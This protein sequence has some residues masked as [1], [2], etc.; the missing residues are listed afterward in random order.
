MTHRILYLPIHVPGT[1]HDKSVKNKRGLREAFERIGDV[2]EMDYVAYPVDALYGR[3]C[4]IVEAFRP[5]LLFTQFQGTDRIT[6]EQLRSIRLLAGCPIVNWNGDYWPEH[7]VSDDMLRLLR[8][9]DLQLVINASVLDNYAHANIRANFWSFGVEPVDYRHLPLS[10]AFDVVFLGN[11]YSEKRQQ[12]NDCLINLPCTVGLFGNGWSYSGGDCNYDFRTAA[13]I[14]EQATIAISDNQ[15]PDALG[16]LSDRPYQAMAAGA[17]VLQQRVAELEEWT[18]F[19]EGIHYIGF[20][21][22]NELP[23]LVEYWLK[24][25]NANARRQIADIAQ[26]FVTTEHSFD[27]RVRQLYEQLLPEVSR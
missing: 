19:I 4:N 9:V 24:P 6:P 3:I 11:N 27:A 21:D 13:S 14:Y 16:Y 5:T 2:C 10:R 1:Y 20:D 15:F 22:L 18:G 26:K 8:E 25:E 23:A 7:L 17:F 12:L